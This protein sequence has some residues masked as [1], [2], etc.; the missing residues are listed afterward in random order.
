MWTPSHILLT[1]SQLRDNSRF[2]TMIITAA[3]LL[4]IVFNPFYLPLVGMIILF[5][6][7]Y[8]QL[9]P[10]RYKLT[11][12]VIVYL[13][14]ILIPRL[15]IRL[16]S[17]MNGWK[18]FQLWFK[19]RRIVPYIISMVCYVA[20]YYLL[21]YLHT[22]RFINI[23]LVAALVLQIVCAIVNVWW[24]VSTHSAGIGG[25]T[26]TL[27]MFSLFFGFYLLWWLCLAIIISGCVCS[28][29]MVL[30]QHTLYEVIGGYLIGLATAITVIIYI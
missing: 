21:A 2:R 5:C 24:K 13:L 17:R 1:L 7:T 22:P 23:I 14:T 26:G 28:A 30:R 18:L 15:L 3:K 27:M 6:A 8:L 25:V 9:L 20:C 11:V 4:C 12:I 10:T 19:E 16:Y 29:R